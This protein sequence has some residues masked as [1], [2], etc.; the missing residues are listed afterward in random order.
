MFVTAYYPDWSIWTL[1]PWMVDYSAITHIIHFSADPDASTPP[2]FS[3][4]TKASDSLKLQYGNGNN[5]RSINF[6]DSLIHYSHKNGVKALLC[7]GGIY[8]NSDA[9][10]DQ[11]C[12]DINKIRVFVGAISSYCKRKGYDGVDVD[13]EGPNNQT[14]FINLLTVLRDTLNT[15]PTPGIITAA[16]YSF[17]SNSYHIPTMAEKLDQITV[18]N[19]DQGT[20]TYAGF[21]APLKRGE[22][23]YNGGNWTAWTLADH[24]PQNWINA[25]FPKSKI[26]MGIPFYGWEFSGVDG[27]CQLR[28]GGQW[29]RSYANALSYLSQYPNSYRW[30]DSSKVPYL[31]F[32]DG[33]GVKHMVSYDD[34]VSIA[35]KIDYAKNLGIGG[36]MI[37]ELHAGWVQN[38]PAGQRDPLLQ[39]LKKAMAGLI[40]PPPP[41]PGVPTLNSPANGAN[42]LPIPVTISWNASSGATSYRVQ[43]SLSSSFSTLLV[44]Q[45]GVT[46]TSYQL[47]NLNFGTAY[48]WRVNASSTNGTSNWSAI[49]NFSTITAA[50]PK[51]K[52]QLYFDSNQNR[53]KDTNEPAMA[54]WNVTVIG[55]VTDSELTD[56]SGWYYFYDLPN[57]SYT[58]DVE[59]PPL[60]T[61]TYPPSS[62]SYSVTVTDNSSSSNSTFGMYSSQAFSFPVDKQWNIVSVPLRLADF[63]KTTIFPLAITDAYSF[64]DGYN[65]ENVLENGPAYWVKM[66]MAHQVW[67]AGTAFTADTVNV[68]PGWNFIGSVSSAIPVANLFSIPAGI[69][70]GN[71]FGYS[72]G[73]YITSVINPGKGY[74]V[75]ASQPGK[76]VISSLVTAPPKEQHSF[77]LNTLN[78]ITITTDQ[79]EAQ[80]LYFGADPDLLGENRNFELPPP[81]PHGVF[82]VRFSSATSNGSIARIINPAGTRSVEMPITMSSVSYPVTIEWNVKDANE[83]YTLSVGNNEPLVLTGAGKTVIYGEANGGTGP[84]TQTMMLVASNRELAGVPSS[85]TLGQNYPNPFNNSTVISFSVPVASHVTLEVYS[86]IGERV[87]TIVDQAMEIGSYSVPFDASKLSSGVYYYRLSAFNGSTEHVVKTNRMLLLK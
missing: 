75:Q 27:P 21:N 9:Q 53:V 17:I 45:S 84:E 2:Y 25:G 64:H 61:Q 15:W 42:E 63:T 16:V 72:R 83:V 10:M 49:R 76:I 86:M 26:A 69:I 46:G 36:V 38:N 20:S 35:Y 19:Y 70:T 60:W 4:I 44:D 81:P 28:N 43:V 41:P 54:G 40:V 29:Y 79:G 71:V 65:V 67:M 6:Q 66:T 85:F 56:S 58:V 13:W 12:N 7:I 80:S 32:T 74:W 39:A 34:S 24:G 47:S 87:A 31:S 55:P 22:C 52:G 1:K 37:Y 30:D 18:M 14:D 62:G 3:P 68:S 50:L 33:S 77:D 51:I 23:A 11:V 82:D 59:P 78:S 5:D 73:N 48:H 8:G 57:G